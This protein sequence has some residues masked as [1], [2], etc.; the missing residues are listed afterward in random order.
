[1]GLGLHLKRA[2]D[3]SRRS[4][5][6]WYR[7][8]Q[9]VSSGKASCGKLLWTVTVAYEINGFSSIDEYIAKSNL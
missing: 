1:M 6:F 9:G 7:A 5:A 8:P 4:S 2:K 3:E